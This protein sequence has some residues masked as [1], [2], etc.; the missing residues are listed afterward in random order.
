MVRDAIVE[1][2]TWRGPGLNRKFE[3]IDDKNSIWGRMNFIEAVACDLAFVGFSLLKVE[4]VEDCRFRS[5]NRSHS[6]IG[7]AEVRYRPFNHG[8]CFPRPLN[9]KPS[10]NDSTKELVGNKRVPQVQPVERQRGLSSG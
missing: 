2:P 9:P 10:S 7:K 1:V 8:S 6:E 5:Q 4:G 3:R